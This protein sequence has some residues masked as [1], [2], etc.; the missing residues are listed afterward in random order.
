M[1]E[2][3]EEQAPAEETPSEEPD[4]PDEAPAE[5]EEAPAAE[6][7][8][9]D[10]PDG[11]VLVH[12]QPEQTVTLSETQGRAQ[13]NPAV[14]RAE[15]EGSPSIN[16]EASTDEGLK[17]A[18]EAVD[19][20]HEEPE[21]EGAP[22]VPEPV[23]TTATLDEEGN[24]V[25]TEIEGHQAETVITPDGAF[26]EAE[27]A[28][29]SR[30]DTIVTDE[31]QVVYSGLGEDTDAIDTALADTAAD[32]AEAENE[33]TAD[34]AIEDT[35][36]VSYDTADMVDSPGQSA[37]GTIVVPADVETMP[38]AAQ[39]MAATSAAVENERVAE[40]TEAEP[41]ADGEEEPD[42][43][44]ETE[45]NGPEATPAA[46]KAADEHGIDLAEIE[47]S[48]EGGK[49]TKADVEAAAASSS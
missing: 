45:V 47:G 23:P 13:V 48:G 4:S 20:Y 19:N 27:W 5:E 14:Y 24:A 44:E 10:L 38:E 43:G 2:T 35:K 46:V 41:P 7:P 12:Y 1:S 30:K 34:L 37:G 21:T 26:T 32:T 39:A 3:V 31:G 17:L 8:E 6:L 15:K 49:I 9:V 18:A 22:F 11:W 29:R 33:A 28:G 40:T 25:E 16:V 36:Q 42:D